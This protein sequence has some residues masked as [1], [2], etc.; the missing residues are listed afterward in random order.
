[1]TSCGANVRLVGAKETDG[2]V[3]TPV[4]ESATFC[5]LLLASVTTVKVAVLD[6][7]A[8]GEKMALM[9]QEAPGTKT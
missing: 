2:A 5:G 1:M 8:V 9:M 6:P 7:T 3:A 4:P